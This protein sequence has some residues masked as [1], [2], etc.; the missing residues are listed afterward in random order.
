MSADQMSV[1]QMSVVQISVDQKKE[2]GDTSRNIYYIG[3]HTVL[4]SCH[5]DPISFLSILRQCRS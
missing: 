2:K 1:N 3:Q 5:L 4:L